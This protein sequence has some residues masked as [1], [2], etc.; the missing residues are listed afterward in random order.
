MSDEAEKRQRT[1]AA[2]AAPQEAPVL[3][4]RL[5]LPSTPAPLAMDVAGDTHLGVLPFFIEERADIPA[6]RIALSSGFPPRPLAT[7]GDNA[8]RLVSDV[9]RSGDMLIVKDT[10][11]EGSGELRRGHT[12]GKYVPPSHPQGILVR[13]NVPADNS[14]LFHSVSFVCEDRSR[15]GGPALRAQIRDA[16]LLNKS[17]FTALYLEQPPEQYARW[18]MQPT[19][20]GGAIELTI[21]S[22]LFQT[23]IVVCDLQS[24]RTEVFGTG[25][26]YTTRSFVAYTG[27]H[28]D[29]LSVAGAMSQASEGADQVLFSSTDERAME[30]GKRFAKSAANK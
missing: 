10:G 20:W 2:A 23:E 16:V 15:S 22:F 29:A 9:L 7:D 18:I 26:N 27:T 11:S 3:K 28:Y 8:G 17:K 5:R 24:H 12:N 21:L 13:R 1:E 4:L 25:E 19:S 30:M 6:H 14:C